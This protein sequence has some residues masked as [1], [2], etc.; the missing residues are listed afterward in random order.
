MGGGKAPVN[1][2]EF[3]SQA[4][5]TIS[6]ELVPVEVYLELEYEGNKSYIRPWS[7]RLQTAGLD[8][9]ESV[10]FRVTVFAPKVKFPPAATGWPDCHT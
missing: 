2:G 1:D 3:S 7:H 9:S 10:R 8:T 4:L 5:D 6:R